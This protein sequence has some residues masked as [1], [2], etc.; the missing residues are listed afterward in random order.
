[1]R[2]LRAWCV[3]RTQGR[4]T[5]QVIL[6]PAPQESK[7]EHRVGFEGPESEIRWLPRGR[8]LGCAARRPWSGWGRAP[9]AQE[10]LDQAAEPELSSTPPPAARTS[11]GT[12]GTPAQ[13]EGL[14]E[15]FF[16]RSC[17][18]FSSP[19]RF[20]PEL[21]QNSTTSRVS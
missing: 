16:L 5:N 15:C 12:A 4:A 9:V 2:H 11:I 20:V 21:T 13:G 14:R 17:H 1:M 7:G 18:S 19:Q 6:T 10:A 8:T 3:T